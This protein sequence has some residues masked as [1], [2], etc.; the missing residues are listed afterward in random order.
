MSLVQEFKA[1]IMKGNLVVLAIAFIMGAVFAALVKA[2]IADLITPIIALIVGKPNFEDLTFTIN[3]SHFLYG[4][5]INYLV[6]F[7]TTAAVVFFFIFKPYDK[8]M[9]RR[10]A[11]DP[12][13]K[14]CPECTSDIP[15]NATRCPLCT[16]QIGGAALA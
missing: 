9:Q 13:V 16:A 8:L 6:T 7:L 3:S 14:S 10:A 11:E 5:F 2:F 12:T 4:D 1:F 15:I